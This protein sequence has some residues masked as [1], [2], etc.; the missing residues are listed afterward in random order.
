MGCG[1][2][3]RRQPIAVVA[4]L[5]E[6]NSSVLRVVG[7]RRQKHEAH[8][9]SSGAVLCLRENGGKGVDGR[10][11]FGGFEGEIDLDEEVDCSIGGDR[12]G[13]ETLEEV[14]AIDRVHGGAMLGGFS[15]LV[16]LQVPDQM[17]PDR[18][19]AGAGNLVHRFLNAVLAEVALPGAVGFAHRFNR[20]GLGNGDQPDIR[21]LSSSASGGLGDTLADSGETVGEHWNG[22]CLKCLGYLGV[23]NVLV[24]RVLSAYRGRETT[25]SPLEHLCTQ[26]TQ[27]TPCTSTRHPESP[28]TVGTVRYFF[29]CA[30]IPFACAA[31]WPS[32]ASWRYFSNATM[33][34]G[35]LPSFNSA[36]PSWKL[37]SG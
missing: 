30:S 3:G 14:D 29:N 19:I 22:R 12:G 8:H 21:R 37:A 24:R 23:P 7:K 16:R 1:H 27:C 34:S 9:V 26:C 20:E 15:R 2:A 17:P 32:G 13:V 11:K 31:N 18:E 5:T 36:I 28:G 35:S 4:E 10:A 33:A 6:P 25:L